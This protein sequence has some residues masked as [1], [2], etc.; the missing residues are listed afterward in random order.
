[1][2]EFP[3]DQPADQ[4]CDFRAEHDIGRIVDG[5]VNGM[6][7]GRLLDGFRPGDEQQKIHATRQVLMER[8]VP[9]D[10]RAEAIESFANLVHDLQDCRRGAKGAQQFP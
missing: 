7:P 1:M 2:N 4:L 3:L 6:M 9:G 10:G 8:F 5:A